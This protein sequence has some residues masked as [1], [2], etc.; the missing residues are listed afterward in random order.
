MRNIKD[1]GAVLAGLAVVAA[2][3]SW[4]FELHGQHIYCSADP[5]CP[6]PADVNL[7]GLRITVIIAGI[8]V[9]GIIVL[10]ARAMTQRDREHY[11]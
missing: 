6:Q 1:R 8:I 2:A 7:I 11:I 10:A 4:A 9:A 5:R 3:I